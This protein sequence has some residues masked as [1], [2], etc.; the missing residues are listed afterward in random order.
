LNS[1]LARLMLVVSIALVPALGFQ[2]YTESEARHARQ[3]LVEDE[4]MR[5]MHLV[6]TEQQRI[7]ESAEQVLSLVGTSPAIQDSRWDLCQRLLAGLL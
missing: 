2:A 7:T 6:S 4:A 3:Q 1:L 5:L